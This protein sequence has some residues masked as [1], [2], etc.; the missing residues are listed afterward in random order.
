KR[1]GTAVLIR[2]IRDAKVVPTTSSLVFTHIF[3]GLTCKLRRVMLTSA[4]TTF[5]GDV[6]H[7]LM[8]AIPMTGQVLSSARR[9]WVTLA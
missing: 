8:R 7:C 3:G 2:A 5:V 9:N 6:Q 1:R 4:H